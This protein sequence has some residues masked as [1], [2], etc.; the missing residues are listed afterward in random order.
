MPCGGIYSKK[1]DSNYQDAAYIYLY[2]YIYM[3]SYVCVCVCIQEPYYVRCIKPNE[4]KSP[5]LFNNDRVRHQAMYL[6][7]L[8]NVRVRRAGFAYRIHY[9]RF[10][11]RYSRF[12]MFEESQTK[13]CCLL[14]RLTIITEFFRLLKPLY[15]V[16]FPLVTHLYII[17]GLTIS[18][19]KYLVFFVTLLCILVQFLEFASFK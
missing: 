10:L 12:S 18:S 2:I 4:E 15:T 1:Y 7:L 8:E 19:R 14:D 13:I 17:L 6:G 9:K 16:S 11:Q 5:V 3:F